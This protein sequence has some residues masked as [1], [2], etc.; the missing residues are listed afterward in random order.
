MADLPETTQSYCL[1]RG[2]RPDS[3]FFLTY[4]FA[5]RTQKDQVLSLQ[6]LL[7][8]LDSILWEVSEPA[9]ALAKLGWWQNEL[10][11]STRQ[12]SPHPA[13]QAAHRS[14]L[15]RMTNETD[16]QR[17]IVTTGHL[18][19]GEPM[20]ERCD[21][22]DQCRAV[23][24]AEVQLLAAVDGTRMPRDGADALGAAMVL[25]RFAERINSALPGE[26]WWV[27][28]NDQARFGLAFADMRQADGE[29]SR[30]EYRRSLGE[31]IMGQLDL[32][33]TH[34]QGNGRALGPVLA[35]L[36]AVLERRGRYLLKRPLGQWAKPFL[37]EVWTAWRAATGR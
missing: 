14:G 23:G 27:P 16:L 30:A 11:P 6:T 35:V 20:A 1:S 15:F 3:V 29:A 8:D 9:V 21:L 32:A 25:M 37:G 33:H 22:L 17:L 28:M 7:V 4:R 18:A 36:D 34:V 13:I 24:G 10:Q 26:C 31:E 2:A 12:H 19:Q 5:P